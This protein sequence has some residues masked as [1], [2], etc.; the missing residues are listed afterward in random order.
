MTAR[1][2]IAAF[3]LDREAEALARSA[4]VLTRQIGGHLI[5]ITTIHELQYHPSIHAHIP[6]EFA[7][8]FREQQL[9]SVER[10]RSEFVAAATREDVTHEWRFGHGGGQPQ[11]DQL[12]S[13]GRT[14]DLVLLQRP[15]EK[16][17]Q[18][19]ELHEQ[20]I[21]NVGRP[22]LLVPQK[23]EIARRPTSVVIG[24]SETREATRAAFDALA[25]IEPG[26]SITL[27]H[28]GDTR[29]HE[30]AQG[31]INAMAAAFDRH[32]MKVTVSHRDAGRDRVSDVIQQEALETGAELIATGAFG[33]SRT[34]DLVIG[35]ATRHLM[36]ETRFPLL[37]SK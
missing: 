10:I 31:P 34:Y 16:Y 33:H 29:A 19:Y 26:A 7:Q 23:V 18:S 12:I 1:T 21:R 32:G 9:S 37:L 11:A 28:V 35:A 5:G 13:H 22:V 27:L 4:S 20:L 25:L 15:T 24:W 36:Y 6:Q 14:A 8:Q 30:L 2:L 3:D 17:H